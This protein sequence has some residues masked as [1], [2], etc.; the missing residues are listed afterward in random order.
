M[1]QIYERH[2]PQFVGAPFVPDVY[3]EA[4][5]QMRGALLDDMI[6]DGETCLPRLLSR[7]VSLERSYNIIC[8]LD[9]GRL[10]GSFRYAAKTKDLPSPLDRLETWHPGVVRGADVP[11]L[12]YMVFDTAAMLADLA[13]G[14]DTVF[15]LGGGYGLQLFR[16]YY[17]GGPG[18]ARYVSGESSP[19][20]RDLSCRL[21]ALEPRL[22]FEARPFDFHA[23]DWSALDGSRKALIFTHWS[24]MYAQKIPDSFFSGLAAWPG[25]AVLAFVEPIGF[26]LGGSHPL[27]AVQA[28]ANQ[29]RNLNG[30]FAKALSAAAAQGLVEP[31]VVAKDVFAR[32]HKAFDL[33]SVVVCAKPGR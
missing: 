16:L 27:S 1:K 33:V 12:E 32:E 11:L 15:E 5:W 25:E 3:F 6:A 28:E 8:D 18:Q 13:E 29:S 21:A 17:G 10:N 31:L 20:G 14:V 4:A 2:F 24:L 22:R 30:D 26:Q 9:Q 19:A 7:F 23:P